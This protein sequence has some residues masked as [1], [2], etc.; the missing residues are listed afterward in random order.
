[1][2]FEAAAAWPSVQSN[3]TPLASQLP[4]RPATLREVDPVQNPVSAAW[5][6]P[7]LDPLTRWAAALGLFLIVLAAR[8]GA[9]SGGAYPFLAFFPVVLVAAWVSG[10]A[11]A[12][13]A[14]LASTAAAWWFLIRGP[15]MNGW[16]SVAQAGALAWFLAS[17]VLAAVLIDGLARV[18]ARATAERA[19][20]EAAVASQQALAAELRH[21]VANNLQVVA[22]ALMLQARSIGGT[23]AAAALGDATRRLEL[24]GQA[25]PA[26][27]LGRSHSE[28]RRRAG[29]AVPHPVRGRRSTGA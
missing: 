23:P 21:R 1:M 11:P 2:L 6:P 19:R 26:A 25:A 7:T 14:A 18:A 15:G 3:G 20:A 8:L 12:I 10:R 27:G 17:G 5:L 4:A 24:A 13:T 28:C 22:S 16:P 9:S 29:G